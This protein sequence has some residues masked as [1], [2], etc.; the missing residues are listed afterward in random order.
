MY[1]Q[2]YSGVRIGSKRPL[3]LRSVMP[4]QP[5]VLA[6]VEKVNP[7]IGVYSIVLT[8]NLLYR[9]VHI[10]PLSPVACVYG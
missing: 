6:L 1:L 10:Y 9:N 8:V 5:L 3:K 2:G 7:R 4:T